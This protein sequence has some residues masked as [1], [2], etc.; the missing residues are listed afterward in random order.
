MSSQNAEV[1][2]DSGGSL[3]LWHGANISQI[4]E[5]LSVCPEESHCLQKF[6]LSRP[7]MKKKSLFLLQ[8]SVSKE[9]VK[10][11]P[12]IEHQNHLAA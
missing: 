12:Q 4:R 8:T 7:S 9:A 5:V 11:L 10:V 6:K 1:L 2:V 3:S